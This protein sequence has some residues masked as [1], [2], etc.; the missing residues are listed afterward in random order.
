MSIYI[1]SSTL[2]IKTKSITCEY[3]TRLIKV[4]IGVIAA[5]LISDDDGRISQC[6]C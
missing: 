3:Y 2:K 1:G 4:C 5:K 6:Y